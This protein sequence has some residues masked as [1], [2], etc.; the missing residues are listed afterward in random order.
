MRNENALAAALA[1]GGYRMFGDR[2]YPDNRSTSTVIDEN[3]VANS[4]GG[5]GMHGFGYVDMGNLSFNGD[6]HAGDLGKLPW[7]PTFSDESTF[8]SNNPS[9]TISLGDGGSWT[10]RNDSRANAPFSSE[11][12]Y[13]PVVSQLNQLGEFPWQPS[14][15]QELQRYYTSEKGKGIDRVNM[16]IPYRQN[17]IK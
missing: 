1:P 2:L 4:L 14:K 8:A 11:D 5:V 6:G 17:I 10:A 13:S 15:I 3:T 7:H 9:G 16:P 12:V